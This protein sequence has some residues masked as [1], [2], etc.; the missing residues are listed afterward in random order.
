MVDISAT[1]DVAAINVARE[2]RTYETTE[3]DPGRL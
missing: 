1:R 3:L 2:Y